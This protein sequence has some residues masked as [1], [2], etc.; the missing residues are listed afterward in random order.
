MSL[1]KNDL[2][3][4]ELFGYTM[5]VAIVLISA[6][7]LY[8][9]GMGAISSS[10]K[11]MESLSAEASMKGL[12]GRIISSQEAGPGNIVAYEMA[13]PGGY[14]LVSMGKNDDHCSISL[15]MNGVPV[16]TI[17]TG[18]ITLE[19][20]FRPIRIEGCAI[21]YNDTGVSSFIKDPPINTIT[22]PSGKIALYIFTTCIESE[23]LICHVN[24]PITLGIKYIGSS[25]VK[26]GLNDG[27]VLSL[28]IDTSEAGVW[29]SYLNGIGLNATTVNGSVIATS[30]RVA[31]AYVTTTVV[32]ISRI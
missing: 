24:K 19:E 11:D 3:I 15:L 14:E 17:N 12:A 22:L 27:D 30:G 4:S 5:I 13:I 8:S 16:E 7:A 1:A 23:P 25:S 32:S 9:T 6:T 10:L 28:I 2:A 21:I 26:Y 20:P 18:S 29:E 31:E